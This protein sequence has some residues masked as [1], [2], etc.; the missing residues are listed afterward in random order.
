[1][2]SKFEWKRSPGGPYLAR[3]GEDRDKCDCCGAK[4]TQVFPEEDYEGTQYVGALM[5]E[6]SGGYGMLIDDD[7]YSD[8]EN[9]VLLCVDCGKRLIEQFPCILA[10]KE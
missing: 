3:V 9:R 5:V 8:L 6:V 10:P 1:M 2:S 4:M 7:V